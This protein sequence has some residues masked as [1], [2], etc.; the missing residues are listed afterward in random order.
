M[1]Q[2]DNVTRH[3]PSAGE[4]LAW[5]GWFRFTAIVGVVMIHTNGLTAVTLYGQG[6]SVGQLALLLDFVSRWSVPAFVMASG[7]MLLDPTRFRG[8]GH[9][10][11][12]RASRL[13]PPLIVWHVVYAAWVLHLRGD[14]DLPALLQAASVGKLYTALYFFWIVLGLAVVTP[15][16]VPW[17]A[18][19]DV[20]QVTIV[21]LALAALPAVTMALVPV[22]P[23]SEQWVRTA[24]TWWIPYLGYFVLGYA[25]RRMPLTAAGG[26]LSVVSFVAGT[27][28]VVWQWGRTSGV[29]AL[30]EHVQPA[31]SYFH[32]GVFLAAC[33]AMYLTRVLVREGGV[34]RG[35]A[36]SRAAAWGRTLGASTLGVYGVHQL[37]LAMVERAPVLGD[38]PVASSP[39]QL[40]ARCLLVVVGSYAFALAAARIPLLNRIV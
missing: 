40:L 19:V 14:V 24:V 3:T 36:G 15:A 9:F 39:A 5:L 12:R 22:A 29:G 10:L 11:R 37:V 33:S 27:A 4:S 18:A 28:W 35:F 17:V 1:A 30:L 7:A 23:A 34:L 16:L 13:V 26:V 8:A 2:G 38:G 25:V 20:R 32:P 6:T 31:E 21:G